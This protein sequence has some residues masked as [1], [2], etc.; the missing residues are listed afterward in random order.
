MGVRYPVS[1]ANATAILAATASSNQ[2]IY[3]ITSGKV[4]WLRGLSVA[5][6]ATTGPLSLKDAT[7]GSTATTPV[8]VVD[9]LVSA[10]VG[11]VANVLNLRPPGIKFS[12]NVVAMLDA[13]GSVPI[14]RCTV[15]GYEE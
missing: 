7:V 3:G 14:G 15:W 8:L 6:N 10:S 1:G 5:V 13:S 4:F 2:Q 9:L 12:T 11:P